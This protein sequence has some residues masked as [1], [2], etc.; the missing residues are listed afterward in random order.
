M[1]NNKVYRVPEDEFIAAIAG[2]IS[3][4]E[5][6][7]KMSCLAIPSYYNALRQ[8]CVEFGIEPPKFTPP[9]MAKPLIEV[10]VE[11]S[12]YHRGLLKKRLLDAK[13]LIEQ[14]AFEDC[15]TRDMNGL[16]RGKL[17]VFQL[18]H[19]NGNGFDNRL[20]NLRLLCPTCHTQTETWC[21]KKISTKVN[22]L[23]PNPPILPSTWMKEENPLSSYTTDFIPHNVKSRCPRCGQAKDGR[24]KLCTDCHKVDPDRAKI[25]WPCDD[26]IWERL[27]FSNFIQVGKDLGI[28]DNAIRKHLGLKK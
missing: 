22:E 18:D 20:E 1:P 16:W 23:P 4:A 24:A 19:I 13:L 7:A 11:N 25:D 5:A 6:L 15:P 3:I 9:S 2:S 10:L 17:I 26:E 28:S 14:C 12:T 8:R 21:G 27:E